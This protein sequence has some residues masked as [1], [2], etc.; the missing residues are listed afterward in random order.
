MKNAQ[1]TSDI[2]IAGAVKGTGTRNELLGF[3]KWGDREEHLMK[4]NIR[5]TLLMI[6]CHYIQNNLLSIM[7]WGEAREFSY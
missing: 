1:V 2:Q 5:I 4:D 6:R 7:L 3:I